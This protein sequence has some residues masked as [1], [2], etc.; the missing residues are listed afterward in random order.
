MRSA[1]ATV[2]ARWPLSAA[3]PPPPK[4]P[5]APQVPLQ[6]KMAWILQLEDQRLLRFDLP[7]P[8]PPPPPVEGEEAGAGRDAAAALVVARSRGA[9]P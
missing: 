5:D 6:Q 8:P 4:L 7:A 9:R 3:L 2:V 1:I